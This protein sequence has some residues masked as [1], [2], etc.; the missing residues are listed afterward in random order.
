MKTEFTQMTEKERAAYVDDLNRLK[1]KGRT[2]V[3]VGIMLLMIGIVVTFISIS[4]GYGYFWYGAILVG[5]IQMI[6][7]LVQSRRASRQL[8]GLHSCAYDNENDLS[9]TS[10]VVS[11]RMSKPVVPV[12]SNTAPSENSYTFCPQCGSRNRSSSR[13]CTTCGATLETS[14]Q[15]SV[16]VARSVEP[17]IYDFRHIRDVANVVKY[18]T[19]SEPLNHLFYSYLNQNLIDCK[20]DSKINAE[21]L[22]PNAP[23]YA[24]PINFLVQKGNKRVAVLLL[25]NG[26]EYR[27]SVLETKE[28]CKENGVEVLQFFLHL[29]NEESYVVERVRKA[30]M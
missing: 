1:K 2:N 14:R 23:K 29:P 27:Y 7:G 20:V 11:P 25:K 28:L 3:G 24:M 15:T 8:D 5:L 30:L 13:F 10:T 17:Q 4:A 26:R 12:V 9:S 21:T 19:L 6:M 22:F 18:E 16:S